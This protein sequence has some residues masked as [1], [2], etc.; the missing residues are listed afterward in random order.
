M[1]WRPRRYLGVFVAGIV[2][3]S[4]LS[5]LA[6]WLFG[7]NVSS[8]AVHIVPAVVAAMVEGQR[9]ARTGALEPGE[10]VLWRAAIAMT[11]IAGAALIAVTAL[12]FLL[13]GML[14]AVV[15]VLPM[16]VLVQ[17]GLIVL[18]YLAINRWFY[19]AG[20]RAAA[21]TEGG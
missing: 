1:I 10:A 6:F 11:G 3:L 17:L 19:V 13:S 7:W 12:Q 15:A 9:H 14:G 20:F 16:R 8:A 18:V 21:R 4:L 2:G 5:G